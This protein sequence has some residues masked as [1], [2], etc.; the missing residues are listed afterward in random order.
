VQRVEQAFQSSE[1]THAAEDGGDVATSILS[2]KKIAALGLAYKPDVDDLRESPAAEIVRLLQADGAQ[3]KA[4]EPFKPNARLDGI[5]MA[6]DLN[7]AI[8]NADM[9]LLLVK[10]SEFTGLDPQVIAS[11]TKA[12]L[13]LDTVNAWNVD[14]WQRAGFQ[15]LRLGV[16]TA[17]VPRAA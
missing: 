16:H 15:L 1:G 6:T 10:H 3:V 13:A 5:R 7:D 11:G 2:G 4:W 17:P 12:R 8:Q 9:I 14:E